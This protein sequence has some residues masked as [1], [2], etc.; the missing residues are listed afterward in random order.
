[1]EIRIKN[2]VVAKALSS[3]FNKIMEGDV[4]VSKWFLEYRIRLEEV[5]KKSSPETDV[6]DG[7]FQE[8]SETALVQTNGSTGE[9]VDAL[10]TVQRLLGDGE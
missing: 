6:I 9:L 8:I 10:N 2:D 7:E 4:P 1:M 5:S 3:I